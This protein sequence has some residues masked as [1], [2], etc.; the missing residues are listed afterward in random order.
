LNKIFVCKANTSSLFLRLGTSPLKFPL[1]SLNSNFF[2]PVALSK[3]N[4]LPWT[5]VTYTRL[6]SKDTANCEIPF[7][8]FPPSYN[9]LAIPSSGQIKTLLLVS[10]EITSLA[11]LATAKA[12]I[13]N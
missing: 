3:H 13:G 5:S 10:P 4:K 6:S 1:I 2:S 9:C 8:S 11:F 12:V 7:L